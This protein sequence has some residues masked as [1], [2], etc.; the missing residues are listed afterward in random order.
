[1]VRLEINFNNYHVSLHK[2]FTFQYGQIRNQ[3]ASNFLCNLPRIYIP[4]WL[5]QKYKQ[6]Q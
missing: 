4:V 6:L 2:I 3:K 5:D 1:M